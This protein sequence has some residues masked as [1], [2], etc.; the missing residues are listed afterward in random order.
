M[1]QES[2]GTRFQVG[3]LLLTAPGSVAVVFRKAQIADI[4]VSTE[5]TS[6]KS[7]QDWVVRRSGEIKQGKLSSGRDAPL[8][9]SYQ[10]A[11][12]TP[13]LLFWLF[14]NQN[15]QR[16]EAYHLDGAQVLIAGTNGLPNEL[17]VSERLATEV[18][19]SFQ[20]YNGGEDASPSGGFGVAGGAVQREFQNNELTEARAT[21]T[22][23]PGTPPMPLTCTITT[24]V[25]SNAG[26]STLPARVGKANAALPA[27]KRESPGLS[28]QTLRSGS[29]TV[30]DVTGQEYAVLTRDTAHGSTYT[31]HA[32]FE[33]GGDANDPLRPYLQIVL[34]ADEIPASVPGTAFLAA[35]DQ[36]L[37]SARFRR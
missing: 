7:L 1:A 10:L 25:Y 9:R 32:E 2:S 36:L 18:L 12:G 8:L 17:P 24:H 29:R 34:N 27:I 35:W 14:P 22:P 6:G 20:P 28:M 37:T 19:D 16:L 11:G 21:I 26:H 23:A 5:P 4:E 13:A 15:I 33:F 31:V 30:A 3:R